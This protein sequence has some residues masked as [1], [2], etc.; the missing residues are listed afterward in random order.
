VHFPHFCHVYFLLN[1]GFSAVLGTECRVLE[2]EEPP[3]F[4]EFFHQAVDIG[5]QDVFFL[6]G[7]VHN[8][9]IGQPVYR[10]LVFDWIE[11]VQ[12]L[13]LEVVVVF[14]AVPHFSPFVGKAS[15][16]VF[17]FLDHVFTF[18]VFISEGFQFADSAFDGFQVFDG[19]L[20]GF[21]NF[22]TN[23]FGGW[24]GGVADDEG[25]RCIQTTFI[26]DGTLPGWSNVLI[27]LLN[28]D[29]S[30]MECSHIPLVL[31][32]VLVNYSHQF[33]LNIVIPPQDWIMQDH[34]NVFLLQ[35]VLDLDISH[36]HWLF[37][38]P[39][40]WIVALLENL[41]DEFHHVLDHQVPFH[42][43]NVTVAIAFSG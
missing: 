3:N 23:V 11:L 16:Q 40:H 6:L 8:L 22:G 43:R 29:A 31:L 9:Q 19:W 2:E 42:L 35:F 32:L 25:F 20:F 18:E 7:Q 14:G 5:H 26:D 10:L 39:D 1:L 17:F 34:G 33:L 38:L 28:R 37:Q 12:T 24:G 4:A 21:E 36:E 30:L 13:V 27:W 15:Y 41:L